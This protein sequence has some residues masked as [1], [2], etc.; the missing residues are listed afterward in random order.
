MEQQT[1]LGLQYFDQAYS[2]NI[3]HRVNVVLIFKKEQYEW[4]LKSANQIL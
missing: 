1:D 3:T 4:R 2:P